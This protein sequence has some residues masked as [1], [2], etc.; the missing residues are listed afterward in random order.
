MKVLS[1]N[2]GTPRRMFARYR[3]VRTAIFKEP[4]AG[5]VAIRGNNLEG[6]RQSDLRVHG[7]PKKA[8]YAYP[9]EHYGFWASE[10]PG[11][12]LPWGSFGENLTIEGLLED[13]VH[14]G[15]RLQIG[16]AQLVVTQP[17]EPCFKLG[18]RFERGDMVKRFWKSGRSGFYLQV[19]VEGDVAAGDSISIVERRPDAPTIRQLYL[20]TLSKEIRG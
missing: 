12:S 20:A 5:R 9:S 7:G 11:V 13:G 1:V 2:V 18:I 10:L 4:V 6:D 19:A 15:D 17:R 14:V 3:V 8:V 16:S